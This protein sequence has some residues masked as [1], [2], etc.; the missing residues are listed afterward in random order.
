MHEWRISVVFHGGA[1][2]VGADAFAAGSLVV[3]CLLV[4]RMICKVGAELQVSSV[5]VWV[6]GVCSC[7]ACRAWVVGHVLL[8]L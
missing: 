7:W 6:K 2:Y 1:C 8:R 5:S 3:L 4:I